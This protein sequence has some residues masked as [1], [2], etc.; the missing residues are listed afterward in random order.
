MGPLIPIDVNHGP[1][2]TGCPGKPQDDST[3]DDCEGMTYFRN[4][5]EKVV[6]NHWC[7]VVEGDMR[8]NTVQDC[9]SSEVDLR[10]THFEEFH[11]YGFLVEPNERVVWYMDGE[12]LFEANQIALS[13]KQS[14]SNPDFYVGQRDVPSEPLS[15]LLNVAIS[16]HGVMNWNRHMEFPISM[17]VDYVRI[18]QDESKGHSLSCSPADHPTAE[19]IENHKD[20]FGLPICGNRKCDDGECDSC[21]GDCVGNMAC[22]A[23]HLDEH[24]F[25][26]NWGPWWENPHYGGSNGE[27]CKTT[28]QEDGVRI[29]SQG[30][31]ACTL[32]RGGLLGHG[33][34]EE[35]RR[36][37]FDLLIE[38]E[39]HGEFEYA[40]TIG[41]AGSKCN[42]KVR[43]CPAT[44]IMPAERNVA[45]CADCQGS[46][47][48]PGLMG[49]SLNID[50]TY[51]FPY[52]LGPW[53]AELRIVVQPGA[54]ISIKRIRFGNFGITTD[55]R[56]H[57]RAPVIIQRGYW[58][59][60]PCDLRVGSGHNS[61]GE[62]MIFLMS[63]M[64]G[65][66]SYEEA[67]ASVS[68]HYKECA[69]CTHPH[70]PCDRPACEWAGQEGCT[71]CGDRM[72]WLFDPERKWKRLRR[73]EA[74]E[75]VAQQWPKVCSDCKTPTHACDLEVCDG[76]NCRTCAKAMASLLGKEG[77][78]KSLDEAHDIVAQQHP[79]CYKCVIQ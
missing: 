46:F 75:F 7:Q 47:Q 34:L 13:P 50:L 12:P 10:A 33:P 17:E 24:P 36:N 74:V 31:N 23:Q 44:D 32:R 49:Q 28:Y 4:H 6:Q 2:L 19:Y 40:V 29:Q 42:P 63:D 3:Y 22:P 45:L 71:T 56:E 1:G 62:R 39:G 5:T 69:A 77:G 79:K 18:Y 38:S 52:F 64:G 25:W 57:F 51:R 72:L 68:S 30:S 20:L 67:H 60:A 73:E 65:S 11:T 59:P 37:A 14:P 15:M 70:S 9:L 54:D 26:S 27:G 53:G 8:A 55:H 61:C 66:L 76:G 48:A 21:P 41:P 43:G 58:A 16:D 35:T 78:H